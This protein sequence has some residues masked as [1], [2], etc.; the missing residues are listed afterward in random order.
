MLTHKVILI[1]QLT[2]SQGSR[3]SVTFEPHLSSPQDFG[4]PSY[5]SERMALNLPDR[6]SS[7]RD[8]G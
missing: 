6:A 3:T 1:T 4:S 5:I 7:K 8:L 2:I